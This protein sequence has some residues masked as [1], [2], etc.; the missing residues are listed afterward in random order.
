[1]KSFKKFINSLLSPNHSIGKDV[2]RSKSIQSNQ[3]NIHDN[4]PRSYY[5]FVKRGAIQVLKAFDERTRALYPVATY[6]CRIELAEGAEEYPPE[7]ECPFNK[8]DSIEDVIHYIGYWEFNRKKFPY[9]FNEITIGIFETNLIP[10]PKEQYIKYVFRNSQENSIEKKF[11]IVIEENKKIKENGKN[12]ELNNT[13]GGQRKI[14]SIWEKYTENDKE[15]YIK[16]LQ[17]YG[18]L[19]NLFRQKAGDM[20]PYLDSKFQETIYARS[21]HSK[22]V[23][24]GNTPHD[25]LSVFGMKRIGIGL[26]T[27]MNS[28]PS[29]QKVMQLKKYKNEIEPLKSDLS[30]LALKI[31]EIKNDRLRQDYVRLGLSETGNIYHYVTRDEGRFVLHETDYPLVDLQSLKNFK[32]TDTSFEFSDN[33]K[34]YKY[35]FGDSQIWMKFDPRMDDTIKLTEFDV[36]IME[37]PFDFLMN[38]Y[39]QM[40]TQVETIEEEMTIAYLPLYSY[41]TKEVEAMSGLNAWNAKPKAAKITRERAIKNISER[42]MQL[43]GPYPQIT[44]KTIEDV[45]NSPSNEYYRKREELLEM[46]NLFN[47]ESLTGMVEK[48]FLRPLNEVYLPVP[49]EFHKKFPNFFTEDILRLLDARK[50]MRGED[51]RPEIKFELILPNGKEMPALLT[52]DGLKNLQSGSKHIT[53]DDGTKFGQKDLG[54]WLLVD[55]LGLKDRTLVTRDWL[56]KKGTDSVKIWYKNSNPL[57]IYIDF[58]PV[59][60]FEAFMNSEGIEN[61]EE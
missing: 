42:I 61:I 50:V 8:C 19:S 31:S 58:A 60:A 2:S 41:R 13:N 11:E 53:K 27:W 16:F 47:D 30:A 12:E 7:I 20:I 5:E 1:M 44:A 49:K 22:V 52:G 29:Y 40:R 37:D 35:T 54:Q 57:R 33:H 18:A 43:S 34:E 3:S 39:F 9:G 25:V 24:L 51:D 45:L 59:G 36:D 55:V 6:F 14:M 28:K 23:D 15:E 21:F 38:A 46:I 17:V 56:E 48:F 4:L 26:K 32:L 10:Q